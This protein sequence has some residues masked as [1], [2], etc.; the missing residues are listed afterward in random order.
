ME[1]Q[2]RGIGG[3]ERERAVLLATL[4]G[5][6]LG[7]NEGKWKESRD[8]PSEGFEGFSCKGRGGHKMACKEGVSESLKFKAGG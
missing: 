1:V 7:T 4:P 6:G 2:G 8:H 3:R 5:V